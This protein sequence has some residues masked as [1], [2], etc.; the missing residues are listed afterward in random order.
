MF[1]Q[2]ASLGTTVSPSSSIPRFSPGP[3]FVK[4]KVQKDKHSFIVHLKDPKKLVRKGNKAEGDAPEDE[5]EERAGEQ[6]LE[7]G[8]QQLLCGHGVKGFAFC[9]VYIFPNVTCT[10]IVCIVT[11]LQGAA[12]SVLSPLGTPLS[13]PVVIRSLRRLRPLCSNTESAVSLPA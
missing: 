5:T 3:T 13:I 6:T 9:L 1:C 10:R 11:H 2:R 8:E 12:Y 4:V 7:M